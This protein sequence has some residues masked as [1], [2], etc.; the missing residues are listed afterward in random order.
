MPTKRLVAT[1][2]GAV[3][4]A[5][6]VSCADE[7]TAV[8]EGGQPDGDPSAEVQAAIQPRGTW[9][10]NEP[11]GLKPIF[12][13]YG[14]TTHFNPDYFHG[15]TRIDESRVRVVSDPAS[16]YGKAIE[17]RYRIGDGAGWNG[18]VVTA[19]LPA[20]PYRE[21]YFRIVF[22]VSANWQWHKAGGK[23]LYYGAADLRGGDATPF[24]L[25][26]QGDGTSF[27]TASGNGRHVPNN[28]PRIT[29]DKYHTIEIHHAASTSGANGSLR[30][31]VDG[32]EVKSFNVLGDRSRNAVKLMNQE[33]RATRGL[34]D[35]RL[36]RLQAFMFWGGQ[37]DVKRVNDWVRLSELY[38]SGEK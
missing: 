35:K 9:P 11:A 18:G 19:H 20:G 25:G 26:W 34:A 10:D 6:T 22:R 13:V 37:G 4:L 21:L 14:S 3:M 8:P 29:R 36:D 17:K 2:L 38:I 31:W 28:V 33:W 12:K 5:T 30:M 23:Y 32:V 16:K 1:L 27:W 7:L 15:V 24:V